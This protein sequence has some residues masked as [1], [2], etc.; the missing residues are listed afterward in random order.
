MTIK[1]K[2]MTIK[3]GPLT[4]PEPYVSFFILSL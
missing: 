4:L 1:L 3:T 2:V